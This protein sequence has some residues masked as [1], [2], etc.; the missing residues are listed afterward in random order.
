MGMTERKERLQEIVG[1]MKE[2]LE[3]AHK[4]AGGSEWSKRC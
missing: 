4:L 3:E 2:L 1:E